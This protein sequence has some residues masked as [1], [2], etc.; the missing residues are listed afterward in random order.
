M[1]LEMKWEFQT[2]FPINLQKAA[3]PDGGFLLF[4]RIPLPEYGSPKKVRRIDYMP[5]I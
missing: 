1:S 5:V 4:G 2:D 3:S